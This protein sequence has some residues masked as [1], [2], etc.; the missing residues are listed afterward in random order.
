MRRTI[1]L[2]GTR[3]PVTL[4]L[5]RRLW[6]ED[7]R[8]I[9]ADSCRFPIGRFSRA[10]AAHY[11]I[12]SARW[13]RDRFLSTLREIIVKESVDWLWP[14]CEEV[15][16]VAFGQDFLPCQIFCPSLNILEQLHNKLRFAE[17]SWEQGHEIEAPQSWEASD[18]PV[19]QDLIWKRKYSRFGAGIR[20]QQPLGDLVPWM[21]QRRIDGPEFS[22]WALCKEGEVKILTQYRCP[23]K[24]GGGAGCCFVP[25][26]SEAVASFAR[27]VA[28][29]LGYTGAL[30][31]DFMGPTPEGKVYVIECNPRMTSGLHVLAP[32]IPLAGIL[33]GK[34]VSSEPS[35]REAQL[36][37]LTLLHGPSWA[38]ARADVIHD[39]RDPLPTWGQALSLAEFAGLALSHRMELHEAT[40]WDLEWNGE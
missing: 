1:L 27:M 32:A 2:T 28:G 10:F 12:P 24:A 4:D 38:D 8:L 36:H 17:W 16:P 21:A 33:N 23:V 26:R 31:F 13:N 30:A 6:R 18:A 34:P 7:L 11:R 3:A 9:G 39:L 35:L 40:T 29:K 25:V 5:A 19:G 20:R 14:S 37:F 15:F 22:S